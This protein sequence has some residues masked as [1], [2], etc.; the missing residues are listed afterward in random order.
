MLS[1]SKAIELN[2]QL[3]P[4]G[5]KLVYSP[6]N[7]IDLVWKDKPM[8]SKE[9][10]FIH[11]KE[12]TGKST[13]DKLADIR[14][15]IRNTPP[16]TTSYSKS[17]PSAD[18]Y[19][20]ATLVTALD[21]IG[22]QPHGF[23]CIAETYCYVAYVLN[24]RGQDIPFNPVFQAYLLITLDKATLFM[25]P[26]KLTDDV[27]DYLKAVGVDTRE[28]NDLWTC[29]RKRD[30]GDGKVS[31]L[32]TFLWSV[33]LIIDFSRSLLPQRHHT[34]SPSCSPISGILCCLPTSVP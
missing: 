17:A 28:Y 4:K 21:S 5:S 24:L 34:R 9:P 18:K 2:N 32:I 22:E 11:P 14:T 13:P 6:Q 3:S 7:L 12:F 29:L 20:V 23:L 10:I 31:F 8:R 26:S 27:E 30:W 25:D 33:F 19:H 1:H 15:W 16:T